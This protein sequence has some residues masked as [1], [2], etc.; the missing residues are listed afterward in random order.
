MFRKHLRSKSFYALKN[1]L[2]R[3][4]IICYKFVYKDFHSNKPSNVPDVTGR[5][6]YQPGDRIK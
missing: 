6:S 4:T 2:N 3:L 1:I 5:G